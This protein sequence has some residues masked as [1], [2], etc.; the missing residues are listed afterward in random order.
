VPNSENGRLSR[1]RLARIATAFKAD[2]DAGTIPGAVA[3]VAHRG[4]IA[5]LQ[6]F[7]YRDRERKLPMAVDSI[8]RIASMTK[9]IAGVAMM[10][11]WEQGK[12]TLDDPVAKHI[13]E[14]ANL[15][16]STPNGEVA[17][18]RPMTM[19]QLMSHSAG[20]DVSAAC[21]WS[22]RR[23]TTCPSSRTSWSAWKRPT[24]QATARSSSSRRAAK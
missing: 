1:E 23:P 11:L 17:Q 18:T 9:P 3:M 24:P 12:W 15:K 22:I 8:F 16:V 7:G 4:E 2:V 6:A 20:L 14:F 13:P 5:Y 10:M 21:G 19:R